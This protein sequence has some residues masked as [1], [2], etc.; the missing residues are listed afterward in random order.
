MQHRPRG[1]LTERVTERLRRAI[2]DGEFALGEAL[3]E[4]K[5]ATKLGV[6][7]SPVRQAFAALEQQGLIHV[8][9]QRGTFVFEPSAEDTAELCEFR[10]MIEIEALD[11]AVLRQR[12]ALVSALAAAATTMAEALEAAD[13][14]RATHAD[15]EFHDAI[16][17]NSGNSY[18]ASAY[19]LVSGKLTAMRSHQ[20]I[21][22]SRQNASAEHFEIVGF[23][24]AGD[25]PAAR[26]AL[27]THILKMA[28]RY[29]LEPEAIR[30]A[31]IRMARSPALDHM[32]PLAD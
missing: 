1:S 16:I 3:S 2:L 7:R 5:L 19:K 11:L 26:A 6:S 10:R 15:Y 27:A 28:A 30:P 31:G 25:V 24:K 21:L 14:L 20:S 18:L 12:A 9:P 13:Y 8:R 17:Q 23:L 32:G 22:P 4:E 29:S